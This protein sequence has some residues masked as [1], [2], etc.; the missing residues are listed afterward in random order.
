MNQHPTKHPPL[1]TKDEVVKDILEN[2]NIDEK[3]NVKHTPEDKLYEFHF[4]W[5]QY[6][7]NY[8]QMWHNPK[9]VKSTGEE[10]PDDASLVI[11]KEVWTILQR[12]NEPG[13]EAP[14][15]AP[16]ID[17][18]VSFHWRLDEDCLEIH[19]SRWNIAID[20]ISV[21]FA[22]AIVTTL[23]SNMLPLRHL[24]TAPDAAPV[25]IHERHGVGISIRKYP[26][27][28]GEIKKD[29]HLR[30]QENGQFLEI[31][32]SGTDI[33]IELIDPDFAEQIAYAMR[34]GLPHV[35]SYSA[36]GVGPEIVRHTSNARI[37]LWNYPKRTG[38]S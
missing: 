9:L 37:R 14:P 22:E 35:E 12:M 19:C 26:K 4:G 8:Y 21:D 38:P 28:S 1:F 13:L 29:I 33:C 7:R 31:S 15:E 20:Q 27:Y 3:S 2:M 5:G 10:H 32:C 23:H 18:N 17:K 16:E 24:Y 11:I 6:L 25:T 36:P 30:W 34:T